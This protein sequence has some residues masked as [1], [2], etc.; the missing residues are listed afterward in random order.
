MWLREQMPRGNVI[1]QVCEQKEGLQHLWWEE[2]IGD[3]NLL[4]SVKSSSWIWANVR[5]LQDH[6]RSKG[7]K[8]CQNKNQYASTIHYTM[9]ITS[10]NSEVNSKE[11]ELRES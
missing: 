1:A 8:D 10:P 4:A 11:A 3:D 7:F 6:T 2:G 5:H 9:K